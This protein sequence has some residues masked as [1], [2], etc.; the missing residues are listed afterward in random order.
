MA[1]GGIIEPFDM[2]PGYGDDAPLGFMADSSTFS[3]EYRGDLSAVGETLD[4]RDWHGAPRGRANADTVIHDL[5]QKHGLDPNQVYWDVLNNPHAHQVG[6]R[7]KP[8]ENWEQ[9]RGAYNWS[10]TNNPYPTDTDPNTPEWETQATSG[11]AALGTGTPVIP[12]GSDPTAYLQHHYLGSHDVTGAVDREFLVALRESAYLEIA[13]IQDDSYPGDWRSGLQDLAES[14]G[15]FTVHDHPGDGPVNGYQVA[16]PGHDDS[17]ISTG[18]G[19]AGYAHDHQDVLNGPD[20]YMGTW[21]NPDDGLF[22]TEPTETIGDYDDA[23]RESVQRDQWSMWDN[24][25]FRL[26]PATGEKIWNSHSGPDG[27]SVPTADVPRTDIVNQGLA[28]A[29][30]FT[31]A[32]R[33]SHGGSA[34]AEGQ[35]RARVDLRSAS[36]DRAHAGVSPSQV[37]HHDGGQA[38]SAGA[39]GLTFQA[40]GFRE[41]MRQFEALEQHLVNDDR[42][43]Q[44]LKRNG[45]PDRARLRKMKQKFK[46]PAPALDTTA[47]DPRIDIDTLVKNALSRYHGA[48]PEQREG[49]RNWYNGARLWLQNYVKDNGG[50][51]SR[52][53]AIMA[54]LSPQLS[55]EKNL[56]GGAH[57]LKTYRPEEKHLWRSPNISPDALAKWQAQTGGDDRGPQ[58]PE[59]W[60]AFA[61]MAGNADPEWLSELQMPGRWDRAVSKPAKAPYVGTGLPMLGDNVLRAM[62]LYDAKDPRDVMGVGGPKIDSFWHNFL[63][64]ENYV[65]IDKHMLRALDRGYGQDPLMSYGKKPAGVKETPEDRRVSELEAQLGYKSNSITGD[66]PQ[67]VNTGYNSY[68]EAIRRAT[69]QVNAG[70]ADPKDHVTPAQ[71]Q[72]IIWLQHKSDMD[73][74]SA[75]KSQEEWQTKNPGKAYQDRRIPK[76]GLPVTPKV[77]MPNYEESDAWAEANPYKGETKDAPNPRPKRDYQN[78]QTIPAVPS[79]N[80]PDA[81]PS[82]EDMYVGDPHVQRAASILFG[83]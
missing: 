4:D 63:G 46:Q 54:G 65:T 12:E 51:Y 44:V 1:G 67:T 35:R 62:A 28:G 24:G 3:P 7:D 8:R 26:D 13:G 22:Y 34:G 31:L 16:I 48:T 38:S 68:V 5:A 73:A 57:F 25:A 71:M 27:Y 9:G 30:G 18:D 10:F 83:C 81:A 50:D 36:A 45:D 21:R 64:D 61:Q 80:I 58:N 2:Y 20:R 42:P 37:R 19:W 32:N 43:R 29:T 49:G 59:E 72:A 33:S 53:A 17:T 23:A 55:W 74:F 41:A 14:T 76:P 75:R 15:G 78:E 66:Q 11:D 77:P 82:F 47:L 79:D 39:Q 60:N 56:E 70:L 69:Q 6:W 52:A 40:G